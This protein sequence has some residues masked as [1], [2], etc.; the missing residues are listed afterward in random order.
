MIQSRDHSYCKNCEKREKHQDL[1]EIDE[2]VFI[3]GSSRT[4]YTYYQCK[5]CGH[6]WQYIED[7]GFGGHGHHYGILTTP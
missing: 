7:S 4:E 5:K 2:H 6:I 3:P 1:I